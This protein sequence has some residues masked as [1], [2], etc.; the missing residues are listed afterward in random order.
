[1]AAGNIKV[2]F[3]V[4]AKNTQAITKLE[5]QVSGFGKKFASVMKAMGKISAAVAVAVAV[6]KMIFTFERAA[7]KMQQL[8]NRMKAAVLTQQQ[9]CGSHGVYERDF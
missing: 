5:N 7:I 1:M 6:G 2:I 4:L 3:Q 8:D 9:Y